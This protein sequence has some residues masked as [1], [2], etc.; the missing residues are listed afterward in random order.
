MKCL[1]IHQ[2]WAS[3][4]V[5][6]LLGCEMRSW[7]TAHRGLLAIHAS[8]TLDEAAVRLCRLPELLGLLRSAGYGSVFDL[9]RGRVLG[10]VELIDCQAVRDQEPGG[11]IGRAGRFSWR[12]AEPRSL[13]EP[14]LVRAK[15][16]IFD[17]PDLF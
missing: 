10:A 7:R 5:R 1:S 15:R 4:I 8:Q 17:I 16:G 11:V 2:P 3:L 9:P 6:G 14:V 12:L 13:A